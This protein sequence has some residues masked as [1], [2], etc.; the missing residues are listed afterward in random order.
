MAQACEVLLLP[1]CEKKAF[2]CQIRLLHQEHIFSGIQ[3]RETTSKMP[4]HTKNSVAQWL[5]CLMY[6]RSLVGKKAIV[7]LLRKYALELV[8]IHRVEYTLQILSSQTLVF[9]VLD[10]HQ[11][12]ISLVCYG[13]LFPTS[14]KKEFSCQIILLH[15]SDHICFGIKGR[16]TTIKL[17]LHTK[18]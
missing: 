7:A 14:D 3:A 2:S 11:V 12:L 17:P 18:Q 15:E 4:V 1:P 8:F 5:L 9:T 16:E 6:R 10:C 13:L